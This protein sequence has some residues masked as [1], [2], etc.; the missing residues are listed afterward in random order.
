MQPG[1]IVSFFSPE[2]KSQVPYNENLQDIS[3]NGRD[4]L[5]LIDQEPVC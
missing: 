3:L 1:P 5:I 2:Q 4:V